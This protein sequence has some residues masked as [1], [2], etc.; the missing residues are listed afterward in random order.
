[1][2][3][4][5]FVTSIRVR[6]ATAP[7]LSAVRSLVTAA[8]GKYADRVDRPPAPIVRDY[9]EAIDAGA[10][11]VVGEPVVGLISLLPGA[12]STLSVENV[13][14]LPSAQGSGVGRH[15][16]EF[17]EERGR[18]LGLRH[19][20]LFTNEAMTENLALYPHLGFVEVDRR[21]DD[22]YQRVYFEKALATE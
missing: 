12:D 9:G 17:A 4:E 15:L 3:L 5:G 2:L 7:D 8:Y 1:M 16:M 19:L 11:W 22:G 18:E 20:V 10:L 13:A 6:R 21:Y 14:V